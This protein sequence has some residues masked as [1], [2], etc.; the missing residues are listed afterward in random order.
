MLRGLEELS[1]LASHGFEEAGAAF[2]VWIM[3]RRLSALQGRAEGRAR[4]MCS[5][6]STLFCDAALVVS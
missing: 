1:E 5:V 6:E 3:S 4:N 2:L